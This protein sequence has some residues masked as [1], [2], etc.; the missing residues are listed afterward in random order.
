[1]KNKVAFELINIAN[2]TNIIEVIK[3]I[4]DE[5]NE[6]SEKEDN[7]WLQI[8]VKNLKKIEEFQ[9]KTKDLD[10]E[11]KSVKENEFYNSLVDAKNKEKLNELKKQKEKLMAKSLQKI[12]V[13]LNNNEDEFYKF[14]SV[15]KDISLVDAAN[16]ELDESI[17]IIKEVID[18]KS[19]L[20]LMKLLNK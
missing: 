6:C 11:I 7:M 9:N 8:R 1:M 10:D 3:Q 13:I 15:Y 4:Y 5:R 16:I 20:S 18:D 17:E 14:I 19:F 12:L 2:K